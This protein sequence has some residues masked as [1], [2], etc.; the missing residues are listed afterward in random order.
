M[1]DEHVS[2]VWWGGRYWTQV[3]VTDH[4]GRYGTAIRD[5]HADAH[6]TAVARL[7]EW[8]HW[9]PAH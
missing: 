2:N 3:T 4:L 9:R 7:H 5:N 8:Q 6:K 1:T